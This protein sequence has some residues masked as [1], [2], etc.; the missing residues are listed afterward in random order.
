MEVYSIRILVL[1][2]RSGKAMAFQFYLV[3]IELI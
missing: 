3:V 1:L 2:Q